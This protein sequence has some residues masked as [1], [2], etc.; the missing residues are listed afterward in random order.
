[1]LVSIAPCPDATDIHTFTEL[2][3]IMA[4]GAPVSIPPGSYTILHI[5]GD[6]DDEGS[7]RCSGCE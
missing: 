3:L 7:P 1:M 6:Y 4:C 5:L 2:S